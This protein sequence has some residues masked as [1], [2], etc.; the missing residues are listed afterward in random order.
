LSDD[1]FNKLN[2]LPISNPF[3]PREKGKNRGE[4]LREEDIVFEDSDL[5]IINKNP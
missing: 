1:E 2:C 4:G 3:L 5:L